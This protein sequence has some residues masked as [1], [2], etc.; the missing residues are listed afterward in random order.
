[1]KTRTCVL[2]LALVV[3]SGW[4]WS[5]VN[6]IDPDMAS[7]TT[8]VDTIQVDF[9]KHIQ[10]LLCR[11]GCNAGS[12]HGSFQGK[13]GL[14]LSL[15][16][17][18]PEKDHIALT[19]DAMGRRINFIDPEQSLV[20]LKATGSVPHGGGKRFDK[21]SDAYRTFLAWIQGG[22]K[23]Q[24]ESGKVESMLIQPKRHRF[25]KTGET[26]SIKV[27]AT[28][29][30]GTQADVTGMCDFR[31]QDDAVAEV[32]NNGMVKAI[33]P[34][35]T[36]VIVS[37]RGHVESASLAIPA[38][39][40]SS[41]PESV[42]QKHNFIDEAIQK[43]LRDLNIE[44]SVLADDLEF[45]RRVTIDTIGKLPSPDEVRAFVKEQSPNKRSKKINELLD[46]PLHSALWATKLCDMTGNNLDMLENPQNYRPKLSK[47]WHDWFRV[48]L[49]ANRPYDE[50]VRGV[51]T[52]TSRDGKSPKEWLEQ[53]LAL[54]K[55][56]ETSFNTEYAKRETLD[57]FYR[58]TG[59][60][61]ETTSEQTAAA[62]MGV[63]IE[64]AQCHKHPF[65]RWT[66]A[67]YRG[68]A[69]T[70]ARVR[71]NLSPETRPLADPI[72]KERLEEAQKKRRQ[73]L[74]IREVFID[75]TNRPRL[76]AHPDT[77]KPLPPQALGGPML[78]G[79]DPRVA[80]AEWLTKPDN[81]YFSRSM[82]NRVWAHYFGIGIV[83]PVDQ[84][85][86]ANP[87]SHPELLDQLA[88]DFS[89]HQFDLRHL[90][91][92]ILNSRTYQQSAKP[93]SNNQADRRLFARSYPRRMMAEVVVDVLNAALGTTENFG[94]DIPKGCQAIEVAPSR[95]AN[96]NLNYLFKIFGRPTRST[97]CDCERT[98]E[99][100]LP[101]TLFLM[102]DPYLLGKIQT[103]RLRQLLAKKQDPE[104]IVEEC[105]LAT[106][107]RFPTNE[108][109]QRT[110]AY[111]KERQ[112]RPAAW[113]D[114][115]WALINTRE[116]ILN[117]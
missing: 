36:A 2:V 10:G 59:L 21:D 62:F 25:A 27:L 14:F 97:T 65:D 75:N 12:C 23:W 87:P 7:S 43:Q 112:E 16:A 88:K 91:R 11:N 76:L 1:M 44:P 51:L 102:S 101:Q 66:Q 77:N 9:E 70:F 100:A 24:P 39:L 20:L 40:T 60:T 108:E 107:S 106:L 52:A 78:E 33:Q 18:S 47:M 81:P 98:P 83:D 79:T 8:K 71:F 22:A 74:Q 34:G 80:L 58:R 104:K 5:A 6:A 46:H 56:M 69:N 73:T 93:S 64:C 96:G 3:L 57:L 110:L 35:L 15:F 48:R 95:T 114:V 111:V 105:F 29:T 32:N 82:A 117:H 113:F 109:K 85:A 41:L 45:L 94:N 72:N 115:M 13:G 26:H 86:L 30:D 17:Y 38:P 53:V 55:E 28:F 92:T 103:G 4:S 67:D 99:P 61:L 49:E 37:Y 90:E 84:F 68:F 50:I 63:R 116:F 89:D 54:E 31:V 42:W 19:Q